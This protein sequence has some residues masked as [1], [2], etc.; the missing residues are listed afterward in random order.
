MNR[1]YVCTSSLKMF[2]LDKP[3]NLHIAA[4]LRFLTVIIIVLKTDC[5]HLLIALLSHLLPRD[6]IQ[7]GAS[8]YTRILKI[9]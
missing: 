7:L 5:Y 4:T 6:A 1:I 3:H 8:S 2:I 9:L